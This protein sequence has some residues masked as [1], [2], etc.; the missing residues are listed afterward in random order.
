[1]VSEVVYIQTDE[2][3]EIESRKNRVPEAKADDVAQRKAEDKCF[4]TF[5]CKEAGSMILMLTSIPL[6]DWVSAEMTM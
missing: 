4:F 1:M 6:Y 3:K 2:E 5:L